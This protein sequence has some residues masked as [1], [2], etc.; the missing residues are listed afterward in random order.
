[1]MSN[2]VVRDIA[3]H[4]FGRIISGVDFGDVRIYC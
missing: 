3:H 1:M 4:Y 2:E